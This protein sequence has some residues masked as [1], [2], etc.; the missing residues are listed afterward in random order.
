MMKY[1]C[2]VIYKTIHQ[3]K[4]LDHVFCACVCVRVMCM[5]V[6]GY[7]CVVCDTQVSYL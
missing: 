7:A 5:C 2:K 4:K 1:P 6:H 3:G